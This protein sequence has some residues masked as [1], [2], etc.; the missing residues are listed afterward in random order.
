[1][2]LMLSIFS[3]ASWPFVFLWRNV[4]LGVLIFQMGGWFLL[5]TISCLYI[6]E[7][8]P[9]LVIAFADV[10]SHSIGCLWEVFY[11]FLCCAKLVS[12]IRSH[13]FIFLF[14]SIALGDGPKKTSI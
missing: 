5:S 14:I 10:F 13:L 8:K 9:L 6:L 3:C 1:M 7:T 2:V 11:G 12:L 4:Y